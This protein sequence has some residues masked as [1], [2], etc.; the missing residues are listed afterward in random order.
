VSTSRRSDVYARTRLLNL[1]RRPLRNAYLERILL[2]A[3]MGTPPR[4]WVCRLVPN[5][6]QYPRGSFRRVSRHGFVMKLD[7]S[8]LVEWYVYWGFRD[9]SHEALV[10]LCRPG[11]TVLDVGANIGQTAL[12]MSVAIGDGRVYAFEPDPQNYSDLLGHIQA[13]EVR[14]IEPY[15]YA[16]GSGEGIALLR[17]AESR[18]RGCVWVDTVD[19][20]GPSHVQVITV[21]HFCA[22]KGLNRVDLIKVDTEGAELS[23]LKGARM[24]IERWKPRVFL[25]VNECNL[26]RFGGSSEAL[27][28]FLI[29][30]GYSVRHAESGRTL[31]SASDLTSGHFDIICQADAL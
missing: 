18:N 16:L 7:I 19:V 23:V 31:T 5:H 27:W 25:E 13:N 29:D 14:N 20:K 4:N 26:R 30:A 15:R 6:Y 8:D 10:S 21:D 22:S 9:P 11:D 17:H 2:K 28:D 1:F 12:R 3:T 24:T